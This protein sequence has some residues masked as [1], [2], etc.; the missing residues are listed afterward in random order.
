ME[1]VMEGLLVDGN[2]FSLFDLVKSF[3]W[4]F[5]FLIELLELFTFKLF[6]V[7]HKVLDGVSLHVLS[8]D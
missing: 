8:I 3:I 6:S 5:E 2:R 7:D 4:N 1:F